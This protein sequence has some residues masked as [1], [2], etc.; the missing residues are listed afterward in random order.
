VLVKLNQI[1]TLTE[2]LDAVEAARSAGWTAVISHRS[3]ET[4]DVFIADLAVALGAGQIKAGAPARGERTAKFNRLVR[5]EDELGREAEF[6]GWNS[7]RQL[8]PQPAKADA[9]VRAR[10]VTRSERRRPPRGRH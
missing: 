8:G 6:A 4:E 5:I 1:G 7:I 3:G 2:T 9:P 10:P